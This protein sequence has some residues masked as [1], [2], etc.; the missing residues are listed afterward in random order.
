MIRELAPADIWQSKPLI[1]LSIAVATFQTPRL[2]DLDALLGKAAIS[3]LTIGVSDLAGV[4]LP[5]E[6]RLAVMA[7]RVAQSFFSRGNRPLQ[8]GFAC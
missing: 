3:T 2:V 5:F 6:N 8:T 7:G 4:V 1:K